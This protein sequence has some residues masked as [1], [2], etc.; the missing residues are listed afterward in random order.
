M[1]GTQFCYFAGNII[2]SILL[3]LMGA[4]IGRGRYVWARLVPRS[5]TV[6]PAFMRASC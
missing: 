5:M 6:K 2:V 1:L 3:A 4:S